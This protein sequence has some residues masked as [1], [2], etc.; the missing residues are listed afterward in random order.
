MLISKSIPNLI[1]GVSQQSPEVRLPSQAEEQLNML[2]SI[3]DGLRRRPGTRHLADLL[4]RPNSGVFVHVINRDRFEKYVVLAYQGDIRVFDLEGNEKTVNKPDGTNYLT[5]ADPQTAFSAVTVADYTFLLNKGVTAR[6][7]SPSANLELVPI[8]K[9]IQVIQVS[10]IDRPGTNNDNRCPP[11]YGVNVAGVEYI[12]PV[13]EGVSGFTAYVASKLTTQ[14]NRPCIATSS[15]IEIPLGDTEAAFS[16]QERTLRGSYYTRD[17]ACF[18]RKVVEGVINTLVSERVVGYES[19]EGAV[20]DTAPA[21]FKE[22]LVHVRQGDYGSDYKILID[23]QVKASLTTGTTDRKTI[24]TIAIATN[25]FNQLTSASIPELTF[26]QRGSV[27]IIRAA[28]ADRDFTLSTEDSL[29]GD[30]LIACKDRVQSFTDLPTVASE[31]FTI[32]VAGQDGLEADDYYVTYSELSDDGTATSGTWKESCKKGL[33]ERP[34]PATMP[35]ALVSEADGTFTFKVLD[36][37]PRVAGDENTAANPS[38]VGRRINDI[39]FFKNR[40]GLLSDENVIFSEAGEYFNFYPT[41]VLQLLPSD[42]IDVAA[43]SEKVSILRQAIPFNEQLLLFS[44]QTQF[45]LRGG[46]VLSQETV[47]I[48]ITT[49]FDSSLLAKP[50]GVGKNVYFATTRGDFTNIREYFVDP[51][52]QLNDAANISSHAPEYIPGTAVNIVGSSTEDIVMLQTN[53]RP[54]SLYVYKFYWQGNEKIQS[55]WSV[56]EFS[57]DIVG[58]SFIDSL[59]VL[60]ISREGVLSLESLDVSSSARLLDARYGREVC[61]DRLVF[62]NQGDALP[63]TAPDLTA[64]DISGYSYS[65]YSLTEVVDNG[66]ALQDIIIGVPYRSYYEFSRF[67]VSDSQTRVATLNGRLMMRFVAVSYLDTE[68]FNVVVNTVGRPEQRI[69]FTGRLLGAPGNVIGRQPLVSGSYRFPLL[70][71]AKYL[72][73][74]LESVGHH[75][76]AFM[77]AEWE[78]N[79]HQ[80]ARRT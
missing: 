4:Q 79:F 10:E 66:V 36:W 8:V 13:S 15:T 1:N 34:V 52:S 41:T 19:P 61:M 16:V 62:V 60:V 53:E 2:S 54:R 64:L 55:S 57:G 51:D 9:R 69:E 35:H 80:S 63:W 32:K 46:D 6:V 44:D 42:P 24:G 38:F 17:R 14:L 48:D 72:T 21:E 20:V 77:A 47:S 74:G 11:R 58:M 59:L 26:Q 78:A 68:A 12:R 49:R 29:G 73:L 76:C 37:S 40:L 65:G 3:V 33:D 31:G 27:I 5:T 45:I 70:A 50:V 25:L 22:A 18:Y 28:N 7:S 23:G 75:P 30:A 43:T 39:F 56:W 71:E 67:V